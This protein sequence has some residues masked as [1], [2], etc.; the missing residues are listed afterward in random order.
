MIFKAIKQLQAMIGTEINNY[1]IT[2]KLG[3]GGMA[4]V[5]LAKHNV[6]NKKMA[7]KFLHLN[8]TE[9]S[10]VKIRF[11]QEA[12]T[13]DKLKHENIVNV[14]NFGK[15]EGRPFLLME[16]VEG[17]SL[18]KY[19]K[20]ITG[21]LPPEKAFK[22][23]L[24]MLA[25]INHAHKIGIIHRDIKPS[26]FIVTP[27]GKIKVLDFGIA[28]IMADDENNLKTKTG[29][30]IGTPQYMSPEQIKGENANKQSDIYALG[31]TLFEMLSGRPPY[32]QDSTEWEL[33]NRIVYDSLPRIKEF[34]P[35]V[36]D[37]EQSIVDKATAKSGKERFQ[38]CN[39]F[40]KAI[41]AVSNTQE[42]TGNS[43]K[44]TDKTQITEDEKIKD[45]SELYLAFYEDGDISENERKLLKRKQKELNLESAQIMRIEKKLHQKKHKKTTNLWIYIVSA[46]AALLIILFLILKPNESKVWQKAT[47]TNTMVAYEGYIEKY[48]SGK[49]T[50]KAKD[51]IHAFKD[52]RYWREISNSND[53][54][55]F[56][57]YL[58]DFPQGKYRKQAEQKIF[59]FNDREAW[60]TAIYHNTISAYE[61]YIA[62]FPDGSYTSSA[63]DSVEVIKAEKFYA[64]TIY[65][66]SYSVTNDC[67]WEITKIHHSDT[68]T[69][70]AM[71]VYNCSG[72]SAFQKNVGYSYYI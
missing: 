70:I 44:Q 72:G 36:S 46:V 57:N 48:P 68:H 67:C 71:D 66:P 45:Y 24:Q 28:K 52:D 47:A 54:S 31:I 25:A 64:Q 34:Y 50:H 20:E 11:E 22:L 23:F 49:Y 30:K 1:T 62:K 7:V 63:E 16:Y 4:S 55:L 35:H 41:K 43:K 65:N 42:I 58:A 21:L 59:E 27:E 19:L 6:L 29:I 56:E 69:I 9:N 2:K 18:D 37:E 39:D 51:K 38:S 17:H 14:V 40:I 32:P 53:K 13:L 10:E 8:L 61:N 60:E 3:E 5:Y 33:S 12:K 15:V 26:N